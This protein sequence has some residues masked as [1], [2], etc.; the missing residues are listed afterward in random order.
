MKISSGIVHGK[1]LASPTEFMKEE[2]PERS[3]NLSFP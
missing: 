2:V 3:E 1:Q